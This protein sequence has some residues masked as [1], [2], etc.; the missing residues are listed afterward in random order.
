MNREPTSGQNEMLDRAI[1]ALRRMPV[2]HSPGAQHF[3]AQLPPQ[4]TTAV[5]RNHSASRNLRSFLMRRIIPFTGVAAV[6]LLAIGWVILNSTA[7][8]A[9]ARVIEATTKYKVV[10]YRLETSAEFIKDDGLTLN[11]QSDEVVYFD[12]RSPRFR[13]ERHD[14]TANDTVQSDWVTVQDNQADRMLVLSSLTL[15]VNEKDADE[16]Q[17]GIIKEIKNSGHL[18][19]KA[20]LFRI[21]DKGIIPFTNMKTDKTFLEIL[22]KLQ[23]HKDIA[24]QKDTLAGQDVTKYRLTEGGTTLILWVDAKTKLPVRIEQEVLNPS[25]DIKRWNWIYSEF[26]WDPE[27][28]NLDELFSLKPPAGYTLEDETRK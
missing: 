17:D 15:L 1:E 14:R 12:L 27:I 25:R 28:E 16:T 4:S 7:S 21:S 10:R 26:E 18:G 13:I 6:T 8:T 24:S 23:S 9:L 11:A 5:Q 22:R 2:P 20:R 3:V 19:K